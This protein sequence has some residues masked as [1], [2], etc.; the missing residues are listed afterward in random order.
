MGAADADM[1]M[2]KE[3]RS[4]TGEDLKK[5]IKVGKF[6]RRL[7]MGGDCERVEV[8]VGVEERGCGRGIRDWE[9]ERERNGSLSTVRQGQVPITEAS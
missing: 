6:K 4:A 9:D 5:I 8:L 2:A 7:V 3:N 1:V